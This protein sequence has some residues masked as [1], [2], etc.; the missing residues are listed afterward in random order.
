MSKLKVSCLNEFSHTFSPFH[1]QKKCV[2]E[3]AMSNL[4]RFFTWNE[5]LFFFASTSFN[6]KF[7]V[8]NKKRKNRV[9][10]SSLI[11]QQKEKRLPCFFTHSLRAS[12]IMLHHAYACIRRIF[13]HNFNIDSILITRVNCLPP[14]KL[15]SDLKI[16]DGI[17]FGHMD[18][19][20]VCHW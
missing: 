8:K 16:N 20:I 2:A 6:L 15:E 18:D 7:I 11:S 13:F 3:L 5:T 9:V 19:G 12:W 1:K 4:V 17:C 10:V 14:L